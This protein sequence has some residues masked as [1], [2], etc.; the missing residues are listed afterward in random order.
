MNSIER[1]IFNMYNKE[2]IGSETENKYCRHCKDKYKNLAGPISFFHVG[3][4]FA[5]DKYKIIFVGKNSWYDK[6]SYEKER[7]PEKSFADA[8]ETGRWSLLGGNDNSMYWDYIRDI[9]GK[10]YS[11]INE[12]E[13]IK[14]IAITNIIKCNTTGEKGISDDKTPKDIVKNCIASRIFE[15]EIEIIK[16]KRII[17]L[18]G[19]KYD[20][21]IKTFNFG[22]VGCNSV[23][24][25]DNEI[26]G[27][28]L[29]WRRKL[30]DNDTLKYS[31]LRTSHPQGKNKV[32]FIRNIMNWIKYPA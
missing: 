30:Y 26:N 22:C 28:I 2:K 20:E 1:E 13:K 7:L 3:S 5:N 24:L 12:K 6:Q 21:Y 8:T 18:T 23:D 11:N 31:I 4:N 15:K 19:N 16:P 14:N 10:L 27:K 17:F 29:N 25:S 32:T 9:I